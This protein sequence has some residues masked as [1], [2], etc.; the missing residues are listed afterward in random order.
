M[1]PVRTDFFRGGKG[2]N[3]SLRFKSFQKPVFNENI[4]N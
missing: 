3:G 4:K 1:I 2:N